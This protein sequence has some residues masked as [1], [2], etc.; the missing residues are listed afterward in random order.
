MSSPPNSLTFIIVEVFRLDLFDAG[1]IVVATSGRCFGTDAAGEEMPRHHAPKNDPGD[2][3]Q[4]AARQHAPEPTPPDVPPKRRSRT[5][6]VAILESLP[7]PAPCIMVISGN[8]C[9]G[10]AARQLPKYRI[11]RMYLPFNLRSS[12]ATRI[13]ADEFDRI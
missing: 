4:Q 1:L 6:A 12:M 11:L 13:I 10:M 2:A 7:E 3:P 9:F 8:Q 5:T